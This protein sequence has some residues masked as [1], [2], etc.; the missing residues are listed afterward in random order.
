MRAGKA[1]GWRLAALLLAAVLT[2]PSAGAEIPVNPETEVL[3]L[4]GA[5]LRVTDPAEIIAALEGMPKVREVR[6]YDSPMATADMEALFDRYYP[7]VFF[8]FTLRIGPHEI[9]TDQTAFSTL[10]L[11]GKMKGD[12]RHNSEELFPLRMCTRMR[13]LD[14]GHNYLTDVNF[15]KWM[16]DLEVLIISPNYGL[17]DI[18]PIAGCKKLVYLECFNT[19]ITD[20]SPLAELKEL[21]DL[22][23]TR[24][25]LVTDIS[26]LYELPKL[27]RVWWGS[28]NH[29]PSDQRKIMREKHRG[30]KFVMV[31]DPTSGG[32]RNHSHFKELHAFFRTGVYVPFSQ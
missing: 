22:N 27:E 8:G 12:E 4:D 26:P 9:R 1:R 31:Y 7:D 21:R 23:L 17:K 24:D 3:D 6:M 18:S 16:P 19:P 5:G 20:L 25:N 2:L 14:L 13:A 10:H 15:L 11:A 30:C 28:M 29:V 32:W